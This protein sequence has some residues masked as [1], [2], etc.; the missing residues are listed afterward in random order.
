MKKLNVAVVGLGVGKQ[1][2]AGYKAFP[3]LFDL[4]TI[5]SLE[6]DANAAVAAELG[7]PETT[8]SFESVLARQDID[9]IDICTPPMLHLPQAK[10]ALAAGK[11]VVCE[12]PL[13]HSV[14]AVDELIVA[15]KASGRRLMPI[16]QYRFGQGLQKLK[17]LQRAG[18]TGKTHVASV[19]VHW[20]RRAPYYA[21]PWRGKFAT[22]LGGAI[23]GHAI[24]AL[25]MLTYVLGPVRRVSAFT[26]TSVNPIEVEDGAAISLEMTDGSLATISVTLGAVD[27]ITR[28]RFVFE[29]LVAESNRA[30]YT[31]SN[32]PWTFTPDTPEHAPAIEAALRAHEADV[33]ARGSAPAAS[34]SETDG[35]TLKGYTPPARYEAQIELFHEA[36]INNTPFP[37][38]LQDARNSIELLTAIYHSAETGQ[39]V[40]LP[41]A[42]THAKYRGWR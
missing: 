12:K 16:F 1:H 7:V 10:A 25:D 36:I 9:V 21:V 29:N 2:A 41:I 28:H 4:Q 15:E 34:N 37:V 26:R 35:N 13:A 14:A 30:P 19:E 11:H 20:R 40:V 33:Q 5:C 6:A 3:H 17:A 38:T 27:E 39:V 42:D 32:D 23:T 31:S 24:H 8:T 22:E 18:L